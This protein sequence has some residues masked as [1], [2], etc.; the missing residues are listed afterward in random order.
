MPRLNI[1]RV[2][3]RTPMEITFFNLVEPKE[4]PSLP[5]LGGDSQA[6][7]LPKERAVENPIEKRA[8]PARATR[9][10]SYPGRQLIVSDVAN[11]TNFIQTVLQPTTKIKTTL[12][13]PILLPNVVLTGE[14]TPNPLLEPTSPPA[15]PPE[16]AKP[17]M[18]R[19]RP[20]PPVRYVAN[21]GALLPPPARLALPSPADVPKLSYPTGADAAVVPELFPQEPHAVSERPAQSPEQAVPQNSPP[22]SPKRAVERKAEPPA[23]A[24]GTLAETLRKESLPQPNRGS[25]SLTLLALTPMPA[26]REQPF[27]VPAGEAR[28]R[29]V[30]SPEPNLAGSETQ[31]GVKS[32]IPPAAGEN[33][34]PLAVSAGSAAGTDAAM[35]GKN[36]ATG[37]TGA[38][39]GRGAGNG[40]GAASAGSGAGSGGGNNSFGGI[41][42]VGGVGNTPTSP[43][44]MLRLP[45]RRPLQTAFGLTIISTE[46]SGGGLPS[47]GV[48]NKDQVYTVYLDMRQTE[49][50][51]EHS[52]T[53]EFSVVQDSQAQGDAAR[54]SPQG[55]QGLVLPFPVEKEEP[56]LPAELVRKNYGRMVIV[57]AIV[58][59]EGKLEQMTVKDSPDPQ[60]NESV[61]NALGKW[62]FRPARLNGEPVRT[63][64]L[65]GIPLW[66]PQ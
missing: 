35:K 27:E 12:V 16:A 14:T 15:S 31:P 58:N 63:K 22:P 47:F 21:A 45:P 10:F 62:V 54:N 60:C 59:T 19:P 41:T 1:L 7:A 51:P 49:M 23:N 65:M 3:V 53:L 28:G 48:F 57:F 61:L 40:S 13:P 5:N 46:S 66:L 29:F 33:G 55:L 17:V 44:S 42:I 26:S 34:R 30:I 50:D 32:G 18:P 39:E 37:G 43:N 52:W 2:P 24:A 64:L 56:V 6:A 25:D 36:S 11:T 8:T 20:P 4:L 9:G 38:N